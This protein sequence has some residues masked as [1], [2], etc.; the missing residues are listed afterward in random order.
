[1]NPELTFIQVIEAGA[2][3]ELDTQFNRNGY[4]ELFTCIIYF[5]VV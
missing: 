1:M 2:K 5:C 4:C 3:W